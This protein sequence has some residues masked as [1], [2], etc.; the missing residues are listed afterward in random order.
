MSWLFG[1]S[2]YDLKGEVTK[3][4]FEGGIMKPVT[5]NVNLFISVMNVF[6]Q[7]EKAVSNCHFKSQDLLLKIIQLSDVH[8]NINQ[9][10]I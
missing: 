6:T 10:L 2:T 8:D 9:I 5:L 1:S 7:Y 4:M 3:L